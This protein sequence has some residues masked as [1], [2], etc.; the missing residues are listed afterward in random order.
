MHRRNI[1]LAALL[2]CAA[3]VPA[4]GMRPTER[5]QVRQAK[6]L[7]AT[8]LAVSAT[9]PTDDWT[10]TVSQLR[11][12]LP[13]D[14]RAVSNGQAV[15]LTGFV[16]RLNSSGGTNNATNTMTIPSLGTG[17]NGVFMV[18][19]TSTSNHLAVAKTGT[20]KSAAVELGE[21]EAMIVIGYADA[22]Y[23]VE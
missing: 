13:I 14:I 11:D 21:G 10:S 1:L 17:T 7:D 22:F 12:S 8:A 9:Q 15:T 3:T 20:W 19:N 5:A 2:L 23:G 6:R 4:Q 18:I 16:I